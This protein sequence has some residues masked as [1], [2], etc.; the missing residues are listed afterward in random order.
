[1]QVSNTPDRYT[2]RSRLPLVSLAIISD[3]DDVRYEFLNCLP[4]TVGRSS[5]ADVHIHDPSV[6]RMH[7][8]LTYADGSI[9]LVDLESKSGV[10]VNGN[11][12]GEC[13]VIEGDVIEMGDSKIAILS[14]ADRERFVQSTLVPA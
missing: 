3:G 7:C 5:Q 4:A 12:L 10:R 11:S 1:M 8:E 2:L 13:D 9:H 6:S 14:I